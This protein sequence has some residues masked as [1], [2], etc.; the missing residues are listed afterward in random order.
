MSKAAKQR[1][2]PDTRR[3]R[4]T[5]LLS[6]ARSSAPPARCC[7]STARG[8]WG[9]SVA[10]RTGQPMRPLS[11][12]RRAGPSQHDAPTTT[13]PR[14]HLLGLLHGVHLLAKPEQRH[15]W[16]DAAAG[17]RASWL[18]LRTC[19]FS[20]ILVP[21]PRLRRR[22]RSGLIGRGPT[23]TGRCGSA[24]PPVDGVGCGGNGGAVSRGN[25]ACIGWQ[26]CG[27]GVVGFG[28]WE[29][30]RYAPRAGSMGE[31]F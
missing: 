28:S 7:A 17:T 8:W 26:S 2:S 14:T 4:R 23:T 6:S 12:S 19:P 29:A 5:H 18:L 21:L 22:T 3:R 16:L 10:Y 30:G 9:G 27:C 13:N 20:D 24:R 15:G 25:A 1:P 11:S 31:R